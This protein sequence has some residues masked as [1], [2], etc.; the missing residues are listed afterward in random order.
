MVEVC[1][2]AGQL[3]LMVEV[4]T[5]KWLRQ[6]P[7]LYTTYIYLY[8]YLFTYIYMKTLISLISSRP[9]KITSREANSSSASQE[10]PPL[11]GTRRFITAFTTARHEFRGQV[12]C[13]VT[14]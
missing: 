13:F 12:K 2:K 14:Q 11:Y 7:H 5:K 3:L 6:E 10:I 1:T 4:C 8:I 9:K